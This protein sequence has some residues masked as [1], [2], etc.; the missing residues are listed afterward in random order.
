MGA[1][2]E[3]SRNFGVA[4]ADAVQVY[5]EVLVPRMFDPWGELL[6]DALQLRPGEALLDVACGP[7]T[8]A[9]L[10]ARR[11]GGTGRVTGCDLSAAMLARATTK[12][13]VD[14]AAPIAWLEGPAEHLPVDDDAF[15]VATCQHGLQF[16]P[17]RPGALREILRALAPGGRL[18]VAVW[19]G[20]DRNP[21]FGALSEAIAQVLG[22]EAGAAYADGP[23]AMTD[24]ELLR[25]LAA[26][27]GFTDV[28]VEVRQGPVVFDDAA[29]LTSTMLVSP[30]A[31]VLDARGPGAYDELVRAT[32]AIVG[33]GPVHGTLEAHVLIARAP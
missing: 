21:P 23:F 25:E 13:A 30:L 18:G 22:A 5:D 31:G 8:I 10:A 17:D 16:F 3:W 24:P 33:D 15:D 1:S 14:G 29:Q 26:G 4:A 11:L 28:R 19:A 2:Q 9:R 6:L 7:G 20:V 12:P 27:A 32:A